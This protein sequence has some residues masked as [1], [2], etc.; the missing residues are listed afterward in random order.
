MASRCRSVFGSHTAWV[1]T[2]S[3]WHD[4][5]WPFMLCPREAA[6]M[7]CVVWQSLHSSASSPERP[8]TLSTKAL[9]M[10]R[11]H[12]W[13]TTGS[14]PPAD[15]SLTERVACGLW[16]SEHNGAF[17]LPARTSAECTLSSYC[18][19][20]FLWQSRQVSI[21]S[22][23]YARL[24]AMGLGSLPWLARSISEWQPSQPPEACTDAANPLAAITSDSFSPLDSVI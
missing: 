15:F 18:F 21:R 20:V 12:F 11:W 17:S 14:G 6:L 4:T 9:A 10:S 22:R 13:Q 16:Q 24:L 8:C 19:M 23:A 5:H 1:V 2:T 3:L 7:L